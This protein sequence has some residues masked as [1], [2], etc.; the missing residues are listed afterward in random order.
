MTVRA[1][2]EKIL[3]VYLDRLGIQR[4]YMLRQRDRL[5]FEQLE[6][7]LDGGAV[8]PRHEW[9]PGQ[10]IHADDCLAV[11]MLLDCWLRRPCRPAHLVPRAG[12]LVAYWAALDQPLWSSRCCAQAGLARSCAIVTRHRRDHLNP[13]ATWVTVPCLLPASVTRYTN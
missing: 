6:L 4:E 8:R 3:I 12:A 11:K 10:L 5:E 13:T 9:K 2:A 7:S 1:V